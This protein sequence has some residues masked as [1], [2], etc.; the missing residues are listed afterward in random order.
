MIVYL[1]T[2]LSIWQNRTNIE[3]IDINTINLLYISV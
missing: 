1:N 3:N 2:R